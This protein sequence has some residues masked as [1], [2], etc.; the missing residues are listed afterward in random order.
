M[1]NIHRVTPKNGKWIV[2]RVADRKTMHKPFRLKTE[3]AAYELEL[4]AK[5]PQ[6]NGKTATKTVLEAYQIFA[7]YKKDEAQPWLWNN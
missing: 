7:A 6:A 3:A 5:A 2:Q 4:V 1:A